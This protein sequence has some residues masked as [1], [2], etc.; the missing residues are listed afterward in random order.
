MNPIKIKQAGRTKNCEAA[1]IWKTTSDKLVREVL[2]EEAA[3]RSRPKD[4]RRKTQGYL[5]ERE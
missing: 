4:G 3:S 2:S 5:R 1:G